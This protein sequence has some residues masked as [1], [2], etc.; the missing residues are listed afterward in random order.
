MPSR[1]S[2]SRLSVGG[3]CSFPTPLENLLELRQQ[4]AV[5]CPKGETNI[6][7]ADVLESKDR[8]GVVHQPQEKGRRLTV[9]LPQN[10]R[11]GQDLLIALAQERS[12][13]RTVYWTV[14]VH[15]THVAAQHGH[16]DI[17]ES[18]VWELLQTLF[19]PQAVVVAYDSDTHARCVL[20]QSS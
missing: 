2:Q 4:L 11:M 8:L 3:G 16:V 13:P 15:K 1:G 19:L 20:S 9:E 17:F 5:T 6:L 10:R 7:T 18:R 12:Q 14:S